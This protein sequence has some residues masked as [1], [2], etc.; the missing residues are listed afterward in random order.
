MPDGDYFDSRAFTEF[1]SDKSWLTLEYIRKKFQE[2]KNQFNQTGF[3]TY[4]DIE[5]ICYKLLDES[6]QLVQLKAKRFPLIIVDECQDLSWIQLQILKKL[7]D[8][9]ARV[10]FVGDLNQGIYAF[11]KVFPEKVKKF[12]EENR[13]LVLKLSRNF[14]SS[15]PIVDLC[16]KIIDQGDIA[17]EPASGNK[18]PE[19][20]YFTYNKGE[21]Q[22]LVACFVSYL[23]GRKIAPQNCA[24][25]ARGHSTV[26]KLRPGASRV[27]DKKALW[28]P[29]A[30]HL[31]INNNPS[32]MEESLKCIGRFVS[33]NF[34]PSESANS[35]AYYCPE[36][37]S[38][39]I[40]WRLFLARIL[41]KCIKSEALC[42]LNKIWK[43][44]AKAIREQFKKIV[45]SSSKVEL[46]TLNNSNFTFTALHGESN[47]RVI[48][49]LGTAKI[50]ND[51]DIL[52]TTFHKVKG[53]TFEAIFVVSAPNKKSNGGHWSQWI[54]KKGS[55]DEHA[56]F[57]YVAG[58][59]PE[60]LLGWAVPS[61]SK[62][63]KKQLVELGFSAIDS[64]D[65]EL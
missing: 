31:W 65:N 60:I 41:D 48:D 54:N 1:R 62:D 33:N 34:F 52:I 56:R 18:D 59:R 11:K 47:S 35:R 64:V 42:D 55:D 25:V 49:S 24:I 12:V 28:L 58:S 36:S 50:R 4:Q 5:N 39:H 22:K 9:G 61:P 14:R 63:E 27:P 46:A 17:G 7:I 13:F 32:S 23:G 44:W 40:Q 26:N 57:A 51:S 38:S 3:A 21:I 10:H 8:A 6:S 45:E 15:Q 53:R 29:T 19:C 30:I 43:D 37:I 16:G 2:K 20:V